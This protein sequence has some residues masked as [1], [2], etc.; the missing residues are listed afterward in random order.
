MVTVIREEGMAEVSDYLNRLAAGFPAATDRD[1]W[2]ITQ[3][4]GGELRKGM[5]M[6]G[7]QDHT[8]R[9]RTGTIPKKIRQGTYQIPLPY[10]A[11]MLD[12]MKPHRVS[13]FSS[14]PSNKRL[15]EWAIDKGLRD[16]RGNLPLSIFV[17]PKPFIDGAFDRVRQRIV[18]ELREG[19]T[20]KLVRRKR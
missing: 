19:E 2:N 17:K 7:I 15:K 5:V 6:A 9:L 1:A 16:S 12:K 10:Y 8:G 18:G 13:L 20:I 11:F 3:M 4:A 14:K